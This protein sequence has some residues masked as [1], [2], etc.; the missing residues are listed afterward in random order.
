[1]GMWETRVEREFSKAS[2]QGDAALKRRPGADAAPRDGAIADLEVSPGNPELV[3]P[4]GLKKGVLR[5]AQHPHLDASGALTGSPY[6]TVRRIASTTSRRPLIFDPIDRV[7][8]GRGY[9]Q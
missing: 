5:A 7:H 8:V 4:P 6:P 3:P 2:V 1:M 9:A